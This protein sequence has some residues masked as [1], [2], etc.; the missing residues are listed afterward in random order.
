MGGSAAVRQCA[1]AGERGALGAQSRRAGKQRAKT[2]RAKRP[3]PAL[4]S[5]RSPQRAPDAG[6]RAPQSGTLEARAGAPARKQERWSLLCRRRRGRR[7]R[8]DDGRA[9]RR[10]RG[11]ALVDQLHHELVD[12]W[13][14]MARRAGGRVGERGGEAWHA[15]GALRPQRCRE[16]QRRRRGAPP[17]QALSALRAPEQ[18]PTAAAA[19]PMGSAM[20]QGSAG[21][22]AA[23]AATNAGMSSWMWRPRDRK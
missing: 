8:H 4:H 22:A 7:G 21:W 1:A 3:P 13:R 15:A 2:S 10:R 9:A 17:Q 14:R 6:P 20:R 16:E 5:R 18:P 12:A 23:A 19:A 11:D